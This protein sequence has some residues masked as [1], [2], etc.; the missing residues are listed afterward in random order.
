MVENLKT[1]RKRKT[2]TSRTEP[3][4][5]WSRVKRVLWYLPDAAFVVFA[6][7]D[8]DPWLL[9]AFAIGV[10]AERIVLPR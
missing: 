2:V 5:L 6:I 10:L 8:R 4:S 7:I 9:A 3:Q 1:L